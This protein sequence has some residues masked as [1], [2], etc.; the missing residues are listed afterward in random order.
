MDRLPTASYQLSSSL[1]RLPSNNA[2][3]PKQISSYSSAHPA[4]KDNNVL[5]L[6]LAYGRSHADPY[7]QLTADDRAKQQQSLVTMGVNQYTNAVESTDSY[8][9]PVICETQ[10]FKV[11]NMP[12]SASQTFTQLVKFDDVFPVIQS[13]LPGSFDIHS[14]TGQTAQR[15]LVK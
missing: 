4:S 2:S 8:R 10:T 15:Y 5:T 14:K 12:I 9:T 11:V 3:Q 6:S 7:P 1:S 13:L